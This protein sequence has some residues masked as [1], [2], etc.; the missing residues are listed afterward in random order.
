MKRIVLFFLF[1]CF[2][3]LNSTN[4]SFAHGAGFPPFFKVNN[5]LAPAS[6]FSLQGILPTAFTPPQDVAPTSYLAN[7]P[8]QFEIDTQLL[9]SVFPEEVVKRAE[10]KWDFGDGQNGSGLKNT[11]LYKKTGSFI[12]TIIADFKTNDTSPQLIESM[13]VDIIPTSNYRI[14]EP[15]LIIN[16][17]QIKDFQTE[18]LKLDFNKSISFDASNSKS[19]AKIIEYLWDFDD[20]NTSSKAK[21]SHKY[22]LPQYF[23]TPSL[24]IKDSNGFISYAYINITNSGKNEANPLGDF[25][26]S[27][28]L[29]LAGIISILIIT[30]LGIVIVLR[31]RRNQ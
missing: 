1:S 6:P 10:Y 24:Q 18:N 8:I 23:A 2:F 30:I 17:K 22:K 25:L 26:D 4:I 7:T 29:V 9:S 27:Y 15:I 20:N 16:S 5:T 21:V 14:P 13:Q 31:R 3:F 19:S 11:H 12:L 28:G